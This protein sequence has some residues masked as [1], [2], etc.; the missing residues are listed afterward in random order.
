MT[1]VEIEAAAATDPENQPWTAEKLERAPKVP[2]VKT[3]RRALR[4]TQEEFAE[5]YM[6]PV[7]TLRDWEQGQTEPDAAGRAYLRAIRGNPE[8]VALA[9]RTISKA[10]GQGDH[11]G[12]THASTDLPWP[13]GAGP[14]SGNN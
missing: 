10:P 5:R 11:A 7:G 13:N 3:M 14:L 1:V 8:A 9:L 4:L 12:V 6:I 2:R